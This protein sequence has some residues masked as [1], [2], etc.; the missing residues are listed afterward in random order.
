MFST[1]FTERYFRLSYRDGVFAYGDKAG[2]CPKQLFELTNFLLINEDPQISCNP[3][4]DAP[5]AFSLFF[6]HK[7]FIL[8][9]KTKEEY[10]KWV[11][12]FRHL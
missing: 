3:P 8:F 11:S 5:Y 12:A 9:S 10:N 1:N 7:K 2:A 4:K 6:K